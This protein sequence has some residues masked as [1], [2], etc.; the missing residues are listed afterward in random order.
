MLSLMIFLPLAGVLALYLIPNQRLQR[1]LAAVTNGLVLVVGGV[2][3]IRFDW[4]SGALQ[5]EE[6]AAWIPALGASYHVAIDGLSL[7]LVLLSD[8]LTF[9]ALVFARNE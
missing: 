7:P 9:F 1:W 4:S 3:A 8:L 6:Q 5:F 2:L